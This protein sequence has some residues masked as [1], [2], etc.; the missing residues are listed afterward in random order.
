MGD[1]ARGLTNKDSTDEILC[2]DWPAELIV[3]MEGAMDKRLP[4]S[5]IGP[6]AT[7][8]RTTVSD[9]VLMGRSVNG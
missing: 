8:R 2:C 4:R 3:I 6:P 5:A 7:P 9:R 1:G